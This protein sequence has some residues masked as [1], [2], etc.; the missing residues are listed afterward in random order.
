[1][2]KLSVGVLGC[3]GIVGE[4]FIRLLENHP[5]FKVDGAY[6]SKN[7]AG[8][9][10]NTGLQKDAHMVVKE[11]ST[12]N[13]IGGRHDI[14]FSAVSDMNAGPIELKLSEA[15][16]RVL[17]NASANRLNPDVPI[18]VP[19]INYGHLDLIKGKSG[20]I[21]ANGNCSTIGLALGIGPIFSLNP[22][23]LSLTTLQSISGAGYPGVPAI[24]IIGNVI[25]FI[26]GEEKKLE[27]ETKKIFGTAK[28]GVIAESPLNINATTTRVPVR[29]GHL[30]SVEVEF[31]DEME[32]SLIL[33]KFKEYRNGFLKGKFPSLPSESVVL[34]TENDRPQPL[35][36]L[37]PNGY[38]EEMQVK[39]GR[40][41]VSGKY[42]SMVILVDNLVRGAAGASILNAEIIARQEGIIP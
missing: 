14:I 30:I 38:Q 22:V 24:D 19:E 17:T 42:V 39:V 36:D 18:V 13:V 8:I 37:I 10:I 28:N 11:S 23:H 9:G 27:L 15:G 34:M 35:L 1:M 21:V 29:N 2:D 12:E 6:A 41:R 40:V 5:W 16:Q 3:T 32:E 4:T 7:S 31:S 25:P 20:Y 33:S 26:K